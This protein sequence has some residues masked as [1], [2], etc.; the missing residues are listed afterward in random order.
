MNLTLATFNI[1]TGW[2]FDLL[3]SW[4]FRRSATAQTINNLGA[5]ILG[6]QEVLEFQ[7]QYIDDQVPGLRWL[8]GG[9]EGG[10]DGEQCPIVL[11]NPEIEIISSVTRWYGTT[12]DEPS[13]LPDASAP[14]VATLARLRHPASDVTFDVAN[15]HLDERIAQNRTVSARQLATWL[16]PDTPT[17]VLGD[18][19]AAPTAPEL[20]PLTARGLRIVPVTGGTAH[21]FSGRTNGRR[22]DHIFVSTHWSIDDAEVVHDRPDGRLPSDHWPVYATLNH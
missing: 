4:P 18:F 15:T 3:N 11:A 2:R 9:R 17:I 8:G 16:A 13:F 22:I 7:R 10:L 6:L 5:D 19:N 12:P 20:A 21:Q 14:R 1:R